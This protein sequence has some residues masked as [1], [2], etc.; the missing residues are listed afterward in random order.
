MGGSALLAA[1]APPTAGS[2]TLPNVMATTVFE[3]LCETF[4]PF[5]FY[6]LFLARAKGGPRGINGIDLS[7]CRA[8]ALPS[9]FKLSPLKPPE[10]RSSK[11]LLKL[12]PQTQF[13]LSRPKNQKPVLTRRISSP[14]TTPD[15]SD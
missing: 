8:S 6:P 2:T 1:A 7:V 10:T 5:F 4:N 11:T 12:S 13:Q 14:L 3:F 15:C 9:Q